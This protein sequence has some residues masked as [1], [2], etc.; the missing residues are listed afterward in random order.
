MGPD[1]QLQCKEPTPGTHLP[2]HPGCSLF[3][4]SIPQTGLGWLRDPGYPSRE[5][6]HLPRWHVSGDGAQVSAH[7]PSG[8]NLSQKTGQSMV[9]KPQ[10][11]LG[12]QRS[13]HHNS[14]HHNRPRAELLKKGA[15]GLEELGRLAERP[16]HFPKEEMAGHQGR[17]R[18]M[19]MEDRTRKGPQKLLT[20]NMSFPNLFVLKIQL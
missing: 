6:P 20:Q 5:M 3:E 10:G 4:G 7:C 19:D 15:S 8:F 17:P 13:L 14:H 12:D 16:L 18:M 9:A 2:D 1:Q 11:F